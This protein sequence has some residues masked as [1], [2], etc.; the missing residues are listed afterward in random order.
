MGGYD[1]TI[2]LPEIEQLASLE[3]LERLDLRGCGR[4]FGGNPLNSI[5]VDGEEGFTDQENKVFQILPGLKCLNGR[6]RDCQVVNTDDE[7]DEDDLEPVQ[8]R[9]S[10]NFEEDDEFETNLEQSKQLNSSNSYQTHE[11][12][13]YSSN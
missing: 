12:L 6:N 1:N 11:N 13:N 5:V 10:R 7:E 8:S 3:H 4:G 9:D 2:A